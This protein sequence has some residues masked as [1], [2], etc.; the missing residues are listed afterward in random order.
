MCSLL[1]GP[2]SFTQS[3]DR[4]GKPR[5]VHSASYV[6]LLGHPSKPRSLEYS[7]TDTHTAVV[8]SGLSISIYV[9]SLEPILTSLTSVRYCTALLALPLCLGVTSPSRSERPR[10]HCSL[11]LTYL[12]LPSEAAQHPSELLTRGPARE[13]MT[14]AGVRR[15]GTS[16]FISHGF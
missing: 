14:K 11:T 5:C 10:F 13:S 8:I 9:G 15:Y 4:D 16:P 7:P 6:T 3:A 1:P 2:I 12:F